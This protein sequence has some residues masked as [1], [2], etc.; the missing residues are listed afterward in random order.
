[1]ESLGL[2]GLLGED[3]VYLTTRRT[4]IFEKLGV[5]QLPFFRSK[6]RN[7]LRVISTRI[8]TESHDPFHSTW[9]TLLLR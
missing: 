7:S 9:P 4:V 1:M 8:H 5:V 3:T 2:I 6:T